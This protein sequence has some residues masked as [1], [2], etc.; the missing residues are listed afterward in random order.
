M[1]EIQILLKQNH[2]DMPAEYVVQ[3]FPVPE[4]KVRWPEKME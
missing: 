4:S 3:V 1:Q 2:Q